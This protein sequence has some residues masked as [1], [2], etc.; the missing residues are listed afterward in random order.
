ML[1]NKERIENYLSAN[2]QSLMAEIDRWHD[3]AFEENDLDKS[4]ERLFERFRIKEISLDL[5]NI[6]NPTTEMKSHPTG[7]EHAVVTYYIPFNGDPRLFRCQPTVHSPRR[8]AGEII[9]RHDRS[10]IKIE[11]GTNY[12]NIELSEEKR[13]EVKV[14]IRQIVE[15]IN[16]VITNINN[17]CNKYNQEFKHSIAKELKNRAE[18]IAVIKKQNEDLNPF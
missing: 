18:R 8:I 12:G 5:E 13:N 14:A 7:A 15:D 6:S 17:D 11:L 2:S 9:D 1:F 10:A 16:N 3:S 4:A